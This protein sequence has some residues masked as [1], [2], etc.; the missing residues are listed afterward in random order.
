[1]VTGQGRHFEFSEPLFPSAPSSPRILP[2]GNAR[3]PI[4]GMRKSKNS[5]E[6]RWGAPPW[7]VAFHPKSKVPPEQVHFAVIGAGFAGLSAAA[8]LRRFAPEKSVLVLEAGSLGSG[9]SGRT[10]GIAL[11]DTAAG[12]LPGLRNVLANYRK[13]LRELR[14]DANLLL[15]AVWELARGGAALMDAA[16][17]TQ[18]LKNSP[19]SW[20]DSGDLRVV[21]KVPG[22]TVDPGKIIS[23]LA[24]A[25]QK[26]GAQIVEHAAVCG[27]DFANP[28]RLHV[29]LGKA[30]HA[31]IKTLLA[32][33]V[34]LATNAG[35]LALSGLQNTGQAKLTFALA[36]A[37]LTRAQIHALGL[38]SGHPFYTLDL[39]YLWGRLFSRNRVIFGSGLVPPFGEAGKRNWAR[40]KSENVWGFL[41]R[42][43]VRKGESAERLAWLEKRVRALH[44]V[45]KNIRVTHRW[46]GPILLANDFRP[47]FCL[48]L[49]SP[50]VLVLGGFSG[51]GVALAVVLGRWAAES[52][53]GKRPLPRW[54]NALDGP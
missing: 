25:A 32:N 31:Q 42:F 39:P 45:L 22:G 14:I 50:S 21:R 12:K 51:H 15:P 23:G 30:R 17:K 53:L 19:I 54:P 41:E 11:E 33:R 8:H 49:K 20:N 27:I 3:H 1:V 7:K 6:V 29:R 52:M 24:R 48:H 36:T 37:P 35:G 46:G 9:A 38:S 47:V 4:I 34:L 28:V 43:D 2:K 18:P 13:T 44:P 5:F 16:G 10:G 26:A 40:T